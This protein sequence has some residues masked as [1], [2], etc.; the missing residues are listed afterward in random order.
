MLIHLHFPDSGSLKAK[1]KDLSSVKAQLHGRY[2]VTVAEVEGQDT[3]QRSTLAAALTAG[4]LATLGASVDR[5]ERYLLD[6]FPETVHME[7]TL[8]SFDDAGG[9]G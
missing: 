3:W 8:T 1:R 5:V 9:L 4:S 2:G 7:R 6:R